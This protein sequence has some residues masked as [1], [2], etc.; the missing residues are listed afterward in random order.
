MNSIKPYIQ[1]FP[2]V[3]TD[4]RLLR[5]VLLD[6]YPENRREIR[7]LT[8][9][10]ECGIIKEL[11][12]RENKEL[13]DLEIQKFLL[14]IEYEYAVSEND[15]RKPFMI[16]LRSLDFKFTDDV[17]IE[18]NI[19]MQAKSEITD[20][21]NSLKDEEHLEVIN[22]SKEKDIQIY[23]KGDTIVFG[24]YHNPIEWKIVK[25]DNGYALLVSKFG[26]DNRPYNDTQYN[27][28]WETCTL[29]K[30]LNNTFFDISFNMNEKSHIIQVRNTNPNNP[31]YGTNGGN[32]TQD[33]IFLLS[34]ND[35][36]AFFSD[37]ADR[38]CEPTSYA[39]MK[40]AG[41]GNA[42]SGCS[43]WLRTP[44]VTSKSA[45]QVVTNG[46]IASFGE[47]VNNTNVVRPALWLNLSSYLSNKND[48]GI[49]R[50]DIKP[51]EGNQN[52][53]GEKKQEKI[54]K[55][56]SKNEITQ[57]SASDAFEMG[58]RI[59]NGEIISGT[60]DE[61]VKLW[62]YAANQGEIRAQFMLGKL[63]NR[64]EGVKID[65]KEADKWFKL[66]A[67]GGD[68]DAQVLHGINLINGD[69][70]TP[71]YSEAAKWI[72]L[73]AEKDS[74]YAQFI[75]GDLYSKGKVVPQNIETAIKW[76]KLASEHGHEIA[77]KRLTEIQNSGYSIVS[78]KQS[79]NSQSLKIGD[80]FTLGRYHLYDGQSEQIKW[81]VLAIENGNA[82]VIS[83]Y[84]LDTK[85]YNNTNNNTT[86]ENCTLRNWL[87]S[88]FYNN[89]FTQEEKFC[90]AKIQIKNKKNDEHGTLGGNDTTDSIFLLSIEEAENYYITDKDRR[91]KPT[92]FAKR[93]GAYIGDRS[94][95]TWW[96]L[97]SPGLDMKHAAF[98][99][100]L[101]KVTY[102]GYIVNLNNVAIRPS[103]W[104]N[105]NRYSH[106]SQSI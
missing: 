75:L 15:S 31:S 45:L 94:S 34:A 44:G 13:T 22:Q 41:F 53:N 7:I 28:T 47:S 40:G 79:S 105:I 64:G 10:I 61:I 20:S 83:E 42:L 11:I 33:L 103:L 77:R 3:I 18:S 106:L 87:N 23:N 67:E 60:Y 74:V 69:G 55:A 51:N 35:A 95:T 72:R 26:L 85:P 12:A 30:W 32:D 81:Q 82:L 25:I 90:I 36:E 29:R 54:S 59:Y 43:W 9:F 16:W 96:W 98:V 4:K 73:A 2:H 17:P 65:K 48:I 100:T 38:Q 78:S 27:I 5:S 102:F 1:L 21:S 93:N 84:G 76:Y 24:N 80:H 8:Y 99:D 66:A 58:N 56:S 88:V 50:N 57:M 97:R 19:D 39:K 89:V 70:V 91:C 14:K 6:V 68:I 92:P 63:Y 52:D 49:S 86:W 101:G 71:N 62:H 104:V 46:K 37:D